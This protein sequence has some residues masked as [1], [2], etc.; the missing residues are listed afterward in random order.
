MPAAMGLY[1]AERWNSKQRCAT[2]PGWPRCRNCPKMANPFEYRS[3]FASGRPNTKQPPGQFWD[4]NRPS[5]VE[6]PD[7]SKKPG[8][9]VD[10]RVISSSVTAPKQGFSMNEV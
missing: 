6:C 3:V 4:L 10:D 8:G 9:G 2:V 1:T 7:S 5:T